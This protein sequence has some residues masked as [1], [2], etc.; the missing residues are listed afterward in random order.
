MGLHSYSLPGLPTPV[1]PN[2]HK[3]TQ[4]H[5]F[6]CPT[7]PFSCHVGGHAHIHPCIALESM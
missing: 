1:T 4:D 6:G 5:K 7:L 3:P 2:L